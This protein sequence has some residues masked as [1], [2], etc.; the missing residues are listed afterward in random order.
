MMDF[1]I[2]DGSA[3]LAKYRG[4]ETHVKIPDSFEGCPVTK[5]GPGAFE[6]NNLYFLEMPS[7]ITEI[8]DAAFKNCTQLYCVNFDLP[9]N[10][11]EKWIMT[12]GGHLSRLPP[13]LVKIG[14]EAFIHTGIEDLSLFANAKLVIGPSAF[15]N[16]KALCE[17]KV[18]ARKLHLMHH[19]FAAC[20][21]LRCFDAG[22]AHT[23]LDQFAFGECKKLEL[24]FF[25]GEPEY[26]GDAFYG[27]KKVQSRMKRYDGRF[28]IDPSTLLSD[29]KKHRAMLLMQQESPPEKEENTLQ[30]E[31]NRVILSLSR[32]PNNPHHQVARRAVLAK[33]EEENLPSPFMYDAEASIK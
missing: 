13:S 19:A 32:D 25:R 26:S 30:D 3:V 8:G 9:E 6:D 17:V 16:C 12:E 27:C 31:W 23:K 11:C 29:C 20:E 22:Q 4:N 14:A 2:Q 1:I 24:L 33:L 15:Q 18:D 28:F 7:T 5:I 10:R 21:N